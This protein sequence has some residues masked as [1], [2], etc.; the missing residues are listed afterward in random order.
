M[1]TSRIFLVLLLISSFSKCSFAQSPAG[2]Q[3][4]TIYPRSIASSGMGEQGVASMSALEAMQYNPA[5]LVYADGIVTSF[6]R[7]PGN[8]IALIGSSYPFT[9]VNVVRELENGTGIG[10]E[11]T[12]KDYGEFNVISPQDPNNIETFHYYER[13]LAGGYAMSLSNQLAIGAQLR[14]AWQPRPYFFNQPNYTHDYLDHLFF[15]TGASYKPVIFSDRLNIGISFMN[16][17][18]SI[19]YGSHVDTIN[20]Q[21]V[22][23]AE[24]D[25][26]P[27]QINIGI[28][29]LVVTNDFFQLNLSVDATKPL[30]KKN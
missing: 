26:P 9:S 13:S 10:V 18:T 5:N 14:Y 7:N 2:F 22:N 23:I 19:E 16:F 25:P 3:S 17:S 6:F 12:Y 4:L 8:L 11:Y 20:G 28:E 15:S 30:D 21:A 29:G 1:R 24:S 27:S